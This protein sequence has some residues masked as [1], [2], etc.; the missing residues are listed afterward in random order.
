[1]HASDGKHALTR[2]RKVAAMT[3]A[4]Q[5]P[6]SAVTS[7]KA[8][9]PE[10]TARSGRCEMDVCMYSG[11]V[12]PP[13]D[14]AGPMPPGLRVG[15]AD[16]FGPSSLIDDRFAGGSLVGPGH[17]MFAGGRMGPPGPGGP[18]HPP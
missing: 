17:P 13:P 8:H 7:R 11:H 10:L 3:R 1:M 12:V 15:D 16:R 18:L 6:L 9:R 5:F 4:P 14:Y 2:A